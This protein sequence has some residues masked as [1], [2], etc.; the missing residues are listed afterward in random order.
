MIAGGTGAASATG[1][2]AGAHRPAAHSPGVAGGN[3]IQVPVNVPVNADG[4]RPT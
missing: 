3:D 2:G 1:H 4:T